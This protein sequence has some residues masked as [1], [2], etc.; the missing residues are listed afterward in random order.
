M[1]STALRSPRRVAIL[2]HA[3][4][5]GTVNIPQAVDIYGGDPAGGR[6]A[7]K[8]LQKAGW[9]WVYRKSLPHLTEYRL[10]EEARCVVTAHAFWTAA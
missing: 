4:K 8:A 2:R 6:A 10:T 3:L 9:L 7:L 5:E 1:G